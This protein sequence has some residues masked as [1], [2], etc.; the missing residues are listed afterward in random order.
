MN[1][2]EKILQRP[3]NERAILLIPVGYPSEKAIV[4]DIHKKCID[5][6]AAWY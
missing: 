6:I 1:F 4:P 2:L 3:S 5:E